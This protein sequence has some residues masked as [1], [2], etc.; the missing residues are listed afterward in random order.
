MR[1]G[2][3]SSRGAIRGRTGWGTVFTTVAMDVSLLEYCDLNQNDDYALAARCEERWYRVRHSS[4][5]KCNIWPGSSKGNEISGETYV[6]HLM[7][8]D[9]MELAAAKPLDLVGRESC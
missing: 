6:P 5:Q 7:D 2:F 1:N 4:E 3:R 9:A 8:H